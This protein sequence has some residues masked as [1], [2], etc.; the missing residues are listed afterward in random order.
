MREQ[1]A[2]ARETVLEAVTELA[3]RAEDDAGVRR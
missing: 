2:A 1:I 3:R